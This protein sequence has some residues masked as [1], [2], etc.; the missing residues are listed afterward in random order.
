MA[1]LAC[2]AARRL[3]PLMRPPASSAAPATA[4]AAAACCLPPPHPRRYA[5]TARPSTRRRERPLAAA[6]L[7]RDALRFRG[8]RGL[9]RGAR[10]ATRRLLAAGSLE[11]LRAAAAAGAGAGAGGGGAPAGL[12]AVHA[13]VLLTRAAELAGAGGGGLAGGAA[14]AG[15]AAETA[16][17][18]GVAGGGGG[19][20]GPAL[21][22]LL[23]RAQALPA[24][25]RSA[26]HMDQRAL[27]SSLSAMGRL[28]WGGA[29]T[30]GE[31]FA[32]ADAAA[33]AAAPTAAPTA[34]AAALHPPPRIAVRSARD[35]LLASAVRHLDSFNGL[36]LSLAHWGVGQLALKEAR[37]A[38]QGGREHG[39]AGAAGEATAEAAAAAGLAAAARPLWPALLPPA[40]WLRPFYARA[41]RAVAAG[42]VAPVHAV[43]LLHASA[44][45]SAAEAR[46]AN[47]MAAAG[48]GEEEAGG[49]AGEGGEGG[50]GEPAACLRP[51][52]AAHAAQEPG[53]A[54]QS[55]HGEEAKWHQRRH[56]GECK[57][58]AAGYGEAV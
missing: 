7:E 20:G 5:A 15:A 1:D 11:E 55:R 9:L 17:A 22:S 34:A 41:A 44:C 28:G 13:S 37:A 32:A 39:G 40:W 36:S 33:G 38:E 35:L 56:M 48:E 51:R 3:L 18:A 6:A 58:A 49:E 52:A 53:P 8:P 25:V 12:N 2:Q 19:G 26:A 42:E 4:A 24:L 57:P 43:R 10:D 21:L 46:V 23:L 30:T 54:D 47:L 31:A 14:G 45:L 50:E 16:Q 29:V 27:S